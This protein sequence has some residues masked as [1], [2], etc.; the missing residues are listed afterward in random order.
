[1]E[2]ARSFIALDIG[3][4]IRE[5][6]DEL[7]RKLKKLHANVRWIRPKDIHL[8]LAFLG[9]V[10]VDKIDLIKAAMGLAGE[11]TAR[12]EVAAAGIGTF[13]R[14]GHPRVIWAGVPACP[15]LTLLQRQL[16]AALLAA[17]I[18]VDRKPFSPHLTL[19]RVK[20][21]DRHTA[22]MLEKIEKYAET[23]IGRTRIDHIGL[24][25]SDLTS[26]GADYTVLHRS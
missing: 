16:V 5:R 22:S 8:T 2:T 18:D 12:F 14:P 19:G 23:P 21:I 11:K 10:P 1:M 9:D 4:E 24:I 25:R 26:R 20:G 13:G 3:D 7:Q 17:E 6:L 15:A